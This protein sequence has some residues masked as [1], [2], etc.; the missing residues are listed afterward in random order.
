MSN[1]S[2]LKPDHLYI[3]P[4]SIYGNK[5]VQLENTSFKK[6]STYLLEKYNL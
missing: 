6:A 2:V 4:K 5:S 3:L 1:V